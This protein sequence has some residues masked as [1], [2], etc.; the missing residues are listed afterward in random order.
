[1]PQFDQLQNS[2]KGGRANTAGSYGPAYDK[3]RD[4]A[5]L[6]H[7]HEKI[8]DWMLTQ[9][10]WRTLAEMHQAL[11]YPES[12]ISA[13]LRHL[14]KSQFGSYRV[15]KRRRR[16]GTG[17]WEYRVLPPEKSGTL[18]L[19]DQQAGTVALR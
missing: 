3:Q 13:Q 12:S 15:E 4:G 18:S 17:T 11:S 16:T 10:D 6:K 19:F 9:N 5:R 7:Q 1:M 14:R 8:R 2:R